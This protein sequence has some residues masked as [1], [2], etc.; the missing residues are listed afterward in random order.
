[1]PMRILSLFRNLFRKRA[2]EQGLDDELRSSVEVLT[3]EKMKQG[4]SE[5]ESR[6][7]ALI[8]LGGVEQVKEEVRAVRAGRVLE[9][10]VGDVHF[11][12][13]TL[14]KSPG[15]TAAAVLTLALGI[16]ASTAIFSV[17]DAVL[18]S[19]LPY[20]N[21]QKIVRVWEQTA[22]GHRIQL[23]DP[24]FEDFRTQNRTLSALAEYAALPLA[25]AGGSEPVRANA[26]IVS[27][28]FFKALGV[29]PLLGRTFVPEEERV[30][31]ARATIV[32]YAYWKQYL[33]GSKELAR[34]R[35]MMNGGV[36]PVVGV[37]PRGF[38]FPQG[39]ALWIARERLPKATSRTAHSW[40]CI[41]R[42]RNGNTIAQARADLDMIAR[43]IRAE[44]G[45]QVNLINAAV[46]PLTSAM[47]GNVRTAV[48]TLFG[49]VILLFLV[50]STN[51]AGLLLARSLARR[52]ELAVRTALGAGRGRLVRQLL[53][54][55][56]VMALAGGGLGVLIAM[57]VTSLLPAMLPTNMPQ[58]HGITINATVLLFMLAST[59]M[60]AVALGV[61][62]AWRA[63]QVSLT[64]ALGAS[65]RS[66]TGRGQ[67][68]R[69]ALVI[70]E[71]G[72]TLVILVGAGL[73][74]RSFLDL[75]SVSP[76][77]SGQ[78]VMLAKISRPPSQTAFAPENQ[79]EIA[80]RVHFFDDAVERLQRIPGVTSA[81]VTGGLPIADPDGFPEGT[82]LILNG[83]PAPGNW[84]DWDRL[85]LDVKQT[86]EADYCVASAGFFRTLGIPLIRGRLFS[87]QDG[88]NTPNVAVISEALAHERWAHKDPI[89]QVIDFGN[90][91]GNLKPLTIIGVVGNI[92]AEGLDQ[93][94]STIIYVDYRQRGFSLNTSPA[95]ILRTSLP[96]TEIV[97]QARLIFHGIDP[98]VP[99]QFSTFAEAMGGWLAERRFVLLLSGAFAGAALVLAAVGVYGLV[100]H[101]VVRRTH[102]IGIRMALGARKRDVLGMII[103]EGTK[104]ALIGVAIGVAGA[105]ALTR[106][107][108]SL[109]F[110]VKPTDP[111]TF[112][113]VSLILTAVALLASY[114]P[115]RR[116]AKVDPMV[117][118][119]YE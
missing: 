117:A 18:L 4:L 95:V 61:F 77:F 118:L 27:R 35:L 91:D 47:V 2:V 65:S 75:L 69:S 56:L 7:E 10:F 13:R 101:S 106:F 68:L 78:D 79:Q 108:S 112:V 104:L 39:A 41:G 24:N 9:D 111:L 3:Q 103:G 51:V 89:G 93:P 45:D 97:P 66:F 74:G 110:G 85:A 23:A 99:V 16:G 55:S 30:D 116:A 25:V 100:A 38:E 40:N 14:A 59:V 28:D 57:V 119:R 62:A 88:L 36:Y 58:A 53:A 73:L 32:S 15:F 6:R 1:M 22:S 52:K 60:V 72:A 114:I 96:P 26:A 44:Y 90:M 12:F 82:F 83:L 94:P 107:L 81:G 31:G 19:P 34:L 71:I 86:G 50:A 87:T 84:H 105:L 67:R 48:L 46:V 80:Q 5:S 113:A 49:A 37:M 109:L 21:P 43:R 42:V 98:S 8:E 63:G 102:E 54:E 20:P 64:E 29:Q 17:V 76:G 11:G 92:R 33:G 115:A 70:G